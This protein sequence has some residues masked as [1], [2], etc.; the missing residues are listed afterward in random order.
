V[1]AGCVLEGATFNVFAVLDG[2]IVTP[3]DDILPGVTRAKV[4]DLARQ[5]GYRVEQRALLLSEVF[6]ASEAFVV[7]TTKRIMPLVTIDGHTI[8]DTSPGPASRH[9][10]ARFR[11]VYF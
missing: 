3:A 7:S 10:L 9:L 11:D 1:N 4:I 2:T 8:G 5:E 6:S